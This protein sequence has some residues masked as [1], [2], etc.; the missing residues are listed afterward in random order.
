MITTESLELIGETTA[1]KVCE[2]PR[3]DDPSIGKGAIHKGRPHRE[4][5]GGTPKADIVREVAW[6]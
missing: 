5:E 4:G 1:A 3:H 6:I 2:A